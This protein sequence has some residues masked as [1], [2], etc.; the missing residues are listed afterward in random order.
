MKKA[1]LTHDLALPEPVEAPKKK[2]A[3]ISTNAPP[4]GRP[5]P[6]T[7][8]GLELPTPEEKE[9]KILEEVKRKRRTKEAKK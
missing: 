5:G 2:R 3:F 1:I 8:H 6:I 7:I 9:A 4:A